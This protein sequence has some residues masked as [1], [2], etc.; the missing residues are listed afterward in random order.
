MGT[1]VGPLT[2]GTRLD[3]SWVPFWEPQFPRM[4]SVV[5]WG[6]ILGLP[7][8]EETAIQFGVKGP[9]MFGGSVLGVQYATDIQGLQADAIP[10]V[11]ASTVATPS[12]VQVQV[13][14]YCTLP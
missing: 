6:S 7:L 1:V 3:V 14:N 9:R 5:C 2:T 10:I 8:C 13:Q 12:S 11:Q 4:R